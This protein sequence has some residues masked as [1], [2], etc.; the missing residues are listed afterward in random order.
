MCERLNDGNARLKHYSCVR[1]DPFHEGLQDADSEL[2]HSRGKFCHAAD[3]LCKASAECVHEAVNTA[4]LEPLLHL[5]D[6]VRAELHELA[7]TALRS[8]VDRLCEAVEGRRQ[9]CDVALEV[10]ELCL[11]LPSSRA[12]AVKLGVS[13]GESLRPLAARVSVRFEHI[14]KSGHTVHREDRVL[15]GGALLVGHAGHSR[16]EL[17]NDVVQIA[18]IACLIVAGHAQRVELLLG[19]ARCC[20]QIDHQAVVCGRGL[21]AGDVGFCQTQQGQRG[22]VN[23]LPILRRSSGRATHGLAQTG[24]RCVR[25][26]RALGEQVCVVRRLAC[27]GREAG[28]CA[29]NVGRGVGHIHSARR[30]QIQHRPDRGELIVHALPGHG[31]NVEAL[32]GL[33]RGEF[34]CCTEFFRLRRDLRDL[35]H[36]NAHRGGD[37]AHCGIKCRAGLHGINAES[38]NC[39][40]CDAEG[41]GDSL[42][43]G[44]AELAYVSVK[45]VRVDRCIKQQSTVCHV[46]ITSPSSSRVRQDLPRA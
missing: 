37:L 38:P 2:Y 41:G 31:Q 22:R 26:G 44:A 29:G 23:G 27:G 11:R 7:E 45:A 10:V 21:A 4:G 43:G 24:D 34:C 5:R 25:K 16:A 46:W 35:I 6:A 20:V 40:S 14:V 32:G 39:G 8:G 30:C 28:E 9:Q 33:R 17:I 1:A 3:D 19:V 12:E 42:C 13:T 36:G 15:G 18:G